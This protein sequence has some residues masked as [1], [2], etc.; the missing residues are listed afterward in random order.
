MRY[1]RTGLTLEQTE[2]AVRATVPK[3][4]KQGRPMGA[5]LLR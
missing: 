3:I 1:L 5:T 2:Q 4:K